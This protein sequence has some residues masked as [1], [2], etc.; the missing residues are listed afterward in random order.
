MK[1]IKMATLT[2]ILAWGSLTWEPKDLNFIKEYGW[3]NDGP[4]LPIE[5]ARISNKGRLTL[6]ITENGTPVTTYF[7]I[8]PFF[9]KVEDV[10]MNLKLREG[11]KLNDIGYYISATN[12]IHPE[13]FPFKK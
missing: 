9:S 7:T 3:Q 12:T 13:N 8:A 11:C 5:F 6:V 2:A 4:L 10:I 1:I